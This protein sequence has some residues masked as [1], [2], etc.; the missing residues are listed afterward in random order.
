MKTFHRS[1]SGSVLITAAIVS[2]ILAIAMG[3]YM[4]LVANELRQTVR[5]QHWAEAVNLAEAGIDYGFA[6]AQ[7][8]GAF[9]STQGWVSAGSTVRKTFLLTNGNV[10]GTVSI[11]ITNI[12]AFTP[13]ITS[14]ATIA[15]LGSGAPGTNITRAV[16]ATIKPSP[17]FNFALFGKNSIDFKGNSASTDSYDSSQPPYVYSQATAKSNGDI[18][19][20]GQGTPAISIGNATING[21]ANTGPGGTVSI[22]SQGTVTGAISDTMAQPMGSVSLPVGMLTATNLGTITATTTITGSGDPNNPNLYRINAISLSGSSKLIF[23]GYS[24]IYVIGSTSTSGNAGMELRM[25]V[26]YVPGTYDPTTGNPPARVDVYMGGNASIS[27]N[28]IENQTQ[29]AWGFNIWGLDSSTSIKLGGNAIM[30]ATV[31]AP[32]ATVE[33]KGGGSSGEAYGAYAGKSVTL[34]GATTFHYDE[35]ISMFGP[36]SG[37]YVSSWEE[38]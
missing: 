30:Y 9:P 24:K 28:G 35:A 18:A 20:N 12:T 23:T 13:Q 22:G 2:A 21:G 19:T 27:G 29:V 33:I 4:A 31:Y 38:L 8:I 14:R 32:E 11:L 15:F 26:G 37:Y 5:A 17:Y 36:K 3:G 7:Y 25:P 34:T 10:V 1:T 16:R 6:Q